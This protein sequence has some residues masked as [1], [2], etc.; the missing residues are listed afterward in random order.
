VRWNPGFLVGSS[1]RAATKLPSCFANDDGFSDAVANTA[2]ALRRWPETLVYHL[3]CGSAPNYLNSVL[4][5]E[6]VQWRKLFDR[7]PAFAGFSDKLASKEHAL[8]AASSSL[9]GTP[10]IW[11]LEYRP[12]PS[13]R[14]TA[15]YGS[16]LTVKSAGNT[17]EAS[18]NWPKDKEATTSL[19]AP[20]S[21]D[22]ARC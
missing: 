8:Q 20:A 14:Y 18:R 6:K 17:G 1:L 9:G 3:L 4:Y 19:V 10:S 2:I 12:E 21:I 22:S 5:T 15:T 13:S 16:R 11:Q 7:N